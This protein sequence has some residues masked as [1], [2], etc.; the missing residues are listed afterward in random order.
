MDVDPRYRASV[1]RLLNLFTRPCHEGLSGPVQPGGGGARCGCDEQLP[2]HHFTLTEFGSRVRI[3]L[4]PTT[5]MYAAL[6][7]A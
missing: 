3:Q 5:Q 1:E 7:L 6:R 2:P 4:N